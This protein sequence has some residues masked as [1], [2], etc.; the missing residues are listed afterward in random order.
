M[1]R[2]RHAH[3]HYTRIRVFLPFTVLFKLILSFMSHPFPCRPT[4]TSPRL[5]FFSSSSIG[6]I[7]QLTTFYC[8]GYLAIKIFGVIRHSHMLATLLDVEF[9]T[10]VGESDTA[11]PAQDVSFI[12]PPGHLFEAL[13]VNPGPS[14]RNRRLWRPMALRATEGYS[15]GK[16]YPVL[17]VF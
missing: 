10:A 2:S 9:R 6:P 12:I 17:C 11:C 4:V 16:W 15:L 5:S 7:W 8:Y 1:A 14:S 13:S 3:I